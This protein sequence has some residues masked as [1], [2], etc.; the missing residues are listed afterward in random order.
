MA[1]S[2]SLMC[3]LAQP[4]IAEFAG[5]VLE[6]ELAGFG[7]FADVVTTGRER[8]V[9]LPGEFRDE[10]LV[11]VGFGGAKKMIEVGDEEDKAQFRLQLE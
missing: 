11:S 1:L 10:L 4:A 7:V 9:V 5:G 2:F 3:Q 6:A 8:Q